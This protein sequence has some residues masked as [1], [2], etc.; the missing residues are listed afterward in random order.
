MKS[1]LAF[2]NHGLL[3]R[4]VR[5]RWGFLDEYLS[6]D[7]AEPGD[8]SLHSI[9]EECRD[10]GTAAD[11]VTGSAPGWKEPWSRAVRVNIVSF[12]YTTI[13]VEGDDTWT[14]YRDEVQAIRLAP[15]FKS[16]TKDG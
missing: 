2:Y 4:R 12:D 15:Q 10:I 11:I 5:L 8:L 9:L 16:P 14:I 3:H 6:V 7:W 1:L 13:T